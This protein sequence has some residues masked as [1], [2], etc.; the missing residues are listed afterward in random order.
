MKS[1]EIRLRSTRISVNSVPDGSGLCREPW[2]GPPGRGRPPVRRSFPPERHGIV[3][4]ERDRPGER[5]HQQ[6][7]RD[8]AFLR[9]AVERRQA[10][11][12]EQEAG[13]GLAEEQPARPSSGRTSVPPAPAPAVRATSP[14]GA[15]AVPSARVTTSSVPWYSP[16][17]TK[18]Q[19]APCQ[20]PESRNVARTIRLALRRR[21]AAAAERDVDVVAKPGRERDVPAAPEVGRA[22]RDVGMVEVDDQLEAEPARHAAGDVR[23]GGEVGVDLDAEREDADPEQLERR[24]LVPEDPA[25]DDGDVV[26]DDQLLEEAPGDE[27]RAR[28]ARRRPRSVRSAS[29]C[30]SRFCA[31]MIGPA[32]RCGKNA[33]NSAKSIGLR[34]ARI[35]PR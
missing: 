28:C 11:E 13:I 2:H 20:S 4:D 29:T 17:S 31:R 16:H 12:A 23:V 32:T 30:R 19:L 1:N 22:V 35:S 5:G 25:G 24:I 15:A 3:Q 7:E 14:A 8:L 21:H 10:Q 26:G 27:N 9:R 33:T 18:F 34:R 6:V